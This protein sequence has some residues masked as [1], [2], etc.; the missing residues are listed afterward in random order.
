[1]STVTLSNPHCAITSA[2][3]PDGMASQPLTAAL[4]DFHRSRSLLTPMIRSFL[5]GVNRR[6][7]YSARCPVFSCW[8]RGPSRP[9]ASGAAPMPASTVG[10]THDI[11]QRP[12][13]TSASSWPTRRLRAGSKRA[14]AE[15]LC[16]DRMTCGIVSSGLSGLG[17]STSKTSSPAPAIHFSCSAL[18][19]A[20]SSTVGPRP[21]LMKIAF[22][23]IWR[24]W[25][26]LRKPTASGVAGRC[27]ETKSERLSTSERLAGSTPSAAMPSSS[28]N[29]S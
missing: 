24:K 3:N 1:M 16:G 29:G 20:A 12:V 11:G 23:F 9:A 14:D 13:S 27:I 17:G 21:V 19:S 6:R 7:G 4:P 2:E 22:F 8:A 26:S 28:R 5:G 15:A 18:I 25:C 10:L